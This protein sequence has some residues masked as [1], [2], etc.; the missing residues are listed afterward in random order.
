MPTITTVRPELSP[1]TIRQ[2]MQRS[3]GRARSRGIA[4]RQ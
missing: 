4:A 3:V 2:F 1:D